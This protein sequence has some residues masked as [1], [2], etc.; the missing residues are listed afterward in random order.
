MKTTE[1]GNYRIIYGEQHQIECL[2]RRNEPRRVDI[3]PLDVAYLE[4]LT[5]QSF[6]GAAVVDFGGNAR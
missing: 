1:T 3:T 6:D 2:N 4:S 5:P